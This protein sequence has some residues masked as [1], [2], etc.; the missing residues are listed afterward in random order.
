MRLWTLRPKY[1]D[2]KGLTAVWRE[3]LLA[4]KVLR[5]KTRGYR[6]HPQL[7]RFRECGKP[8]AAI[9]MYLRAVREEAA[10]RGYLFDRT[11]IQSARCDLR[12]PAARGQME[13]E[14]SHL[15]A[16]VKARDRAKYREL[17]MVLRPDPHPLFRIIRGRR[18]GWEKSIRP[19]ASR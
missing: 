18:E 17:R 9:G 3:G 10:R 4:Q 15:L 7:D 16:K 5:G 2:Q 11:K 8:V 19:I 6:N 12:I 14:W 13:F 1:L